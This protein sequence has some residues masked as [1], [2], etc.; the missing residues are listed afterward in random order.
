MNNRKKSEIENMY[1]NGGGLGRNQH[2]GWA[3]GAKKFT[4]C[5][6]VALLWLA[7]SIRKFAVSW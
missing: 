6:W 7:S 1:L 2:M 5:P 3:E 4:D